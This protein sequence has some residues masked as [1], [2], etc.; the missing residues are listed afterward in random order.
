MESTLTLNRTN[1]PKMSRAGKIL[2]ILLALLLASDIGFAQRRGANTQT[3]VINDNTEPTKP[4]KPRVFAVPGDGRVTIYWDESAESHYDPFF[5]TLFNPITRRLGR[6]PRNFEG[7]MV[8]KSTDPNFIDALRIT[9]NLGNPQRLSPVVRYDLANQIVD[10]HPASIGG[11]RYWLGQDSGLSRIFEDTDVTNGRI[12]YYA[13]VAY[14]HGDALPGFAVPVEFF[15]GVPLPDSL[16]PLQRDIYNYPP[17]ESE[18]DINVGAD[19]TVQ[20]G[21]NTVMVVPSRPVSGFITPLNP[22]ISQEG[23]AGGIVDVSIIDPYN[24]KGGSNYEVSFEDTV[25]RGATDLDP[26]LIVTKNFSLTNLTTGEILIDREEN[27]QNIEL[28]IREGFLLNLENT[29]DSGFV[30]MD[31]TRWEAAGTDRIH[32]FEVAVN[33]RFAKL[34]DYRLEF[35]EGVAARSDTVTLRV[36]GLSVFLQAEDVNFRVYNESENREI[37]FAFFTNPGI[38]RDLRSVYMF[39]NNRGVAVGGGGVIRQTVDGENWEVRQTGV[40]NRL[41]SVH[42]AD[43]NYGWAVGNNGVILATIDGGNIWEQQQ[44]SVQVALNAVRFID[45]Q[46]G[47]AV[48][49]NGTIIRT[50]NGGENW[51]A[52]ASGSIRNL[53]SVFF[54]NEN[55]GWAVGQVGE[56]LRTN[57]GGLTWSNQPTG[58]LRILQSVFF[59]DENTGWVAGNNNTILRTTNGGTTWLPVTGVPGTGILYSIQFVNASNGWAVGAGGRIIRSTDGG[60]TWSLQNSTINVSIY[61]VNVR[62]DNTALAVG[63]GPT[64]LTTAD[65]GTEWSIIPTPKRFR[66]IIDELGRLQS[67]EIYFIEDFSATSRNV[68]TWKVGM[69]PDPRGGT[70]DPGDGDQLLIFTNKPFTSSDRYTF[71]IQDVNL[72]RI[73]EEQVKDKLG[74]IRVVPNPYLVTHVGETSFSGRQLHFTNLPSRCTIRIFSVAGRLLQTIDVN[75]GFDNDRHIWDMRT[76][77]GDEISYGIYIYHV[78]APG[79]GT[80]TGKF[81]VMK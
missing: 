22:Q 59:I 46:T 64:I 78:E 69:L 28:P 80:T 7:Y 63:E 65:A 49:N 55:T 5:E 4:P 30:N 61:D 75:N 8:Y 68:I 74:N 72:P 41:Y 34:N 6:N 3:S 18:I 10:Y 62:D 47:V 52:V 23:S 66:S 12:Y 60:A 50:A 51:T 38:P 16:Q 42:F 40:T 21:V 36:G 17:L 11:V 14:T 35:G 54:I 20:T 1:M 9:D 13:V 58:N 33:T 39:D 48:G 27:F 24:L 29:V 57:D 44:S 31:L 2:L 25:I 73:D 67:D 32:P 81:A 76:K 77:D 43:D 15:Q 70:F 71:S 19:G 45:N 56:I 53:F 79:A 26:D 37:S